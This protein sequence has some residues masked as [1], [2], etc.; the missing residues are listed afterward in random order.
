MLLH[1]SFIGLKETVG[2]KMRVGALGTQVRHRGVAGD[3]HTIDRFD[4]IALL[5]GYGVG[6]DELIDVVHHARADAGCHRFIHQG[7]ELLAL[8]AL[9][10]D[11]LVVG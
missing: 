11:P 9:V 4:D 6:H 1:T 8:T 5:V 2:R 3:V 7:G 10:D